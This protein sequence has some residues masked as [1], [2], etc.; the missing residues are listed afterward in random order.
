M[1]ASSPDPAD[2][3]AVAAAEVQEILRSPPSTSQ[4]LIADEH[5]SAGSYRRP[6][7]GSP[8]EPFQSVTACSPLSSPEE[9]KAKAAAALGVDARRGGRRSMLRSGTSGSITPLSAAP[10]PN[11][12]AGATRANSASSSSNGGLGVASG[13]ASPYFDQ[14]SSSVTAD[15]TSKHL[16][17][18]TAQQIHATNVTYR[19][20]SICPSATPFDFVQERHR[21]SSRTTDG[22]LS[23]FATPAAEGLFARLLR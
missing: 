9:E 1:T 23:V 15:M 3:A 17:A 11:S 18:E 6:S 12:E 5:V 14:G 2:S 13:S 22:L 19:S 20:A 10:S 4:P 16:D 7:S 21:H 8:T